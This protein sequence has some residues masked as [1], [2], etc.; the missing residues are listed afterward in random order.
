MLA[1][2]GSSLL[3]PKVTGSVRSKV[4]VTSDESRKGRSCSRMQTRVS[5]CDGQADA[6]G[7]PASL[8]ASSAFACDVTQEIRGIPVAG[9]KCHVVHGLRHSSSA[10]RRQPGDNK[11]ARARTDLHEAPGSPVCKARNASPATGERCTK[12][13]DSLHPPAFADRPC[14]EAVLLN[15]QPLRRASSRVQHTCTPALRL[16]L[17]FPCCWV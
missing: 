17:L 2:A 8:A 13:P 11:D 14:P 12:G 16:Q 7:L 10:L 9:Q 6:T 15:S 4:T 5:V 1:D 3:T